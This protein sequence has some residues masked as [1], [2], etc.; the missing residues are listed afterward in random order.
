[1]NTFSAE[2]FFLLYLSPYI[3]SII[4]LIAFSGIKNKFI[5][6]LSYTAFFD[7]IAN[8]LLPILENAVLKVKGGDGF[9]LRYQLGRL[10]PGFLD[11][12]TLAICLIITLCI[13]VFYIFYRQDF[14]ASKDKKFLKWCMIINIFYLALDYLCVTL[15][16]APKI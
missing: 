11:A 1:M 5:R 15:F 7:V 12:S 2:G 10:Y 9:F 8:L 4:V 16:I 6:V 14:T 3:V 13:A